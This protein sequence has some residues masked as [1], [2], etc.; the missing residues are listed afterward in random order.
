MRARAQGLAVTLRAGAGQVLVPVATSGFFEFVARDGIRRPIRTDTG[1]TIAAGGVPRTIR[2]GA[3]VGAMRVVTGSPLPA[4]P[5]T[6]ISSGAA[7]FGGLAV[8][9]GAL[10]S[11]A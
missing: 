2:S 7:A 1:A 11:G 9:H 6:R 8:A 4:A 5:A 10:S 3:V